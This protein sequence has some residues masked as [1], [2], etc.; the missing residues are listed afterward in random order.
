MRWPKKVKLLI[1]NNWIKIR[2]LQG[3]CGHAGEPGC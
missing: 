3:C 1:R 2:N